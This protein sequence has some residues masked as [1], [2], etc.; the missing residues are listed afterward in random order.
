VVGGDGSLHDVVNGL[1]DSG[2]EPLPALLPYPVGVGND[3]AR[4]LGVRRGGHHLV[5][6]VR[7]GADQYVDAWRLAWP[8]GHRWF[9]NVASFGLSGTAAA[10]IDRQGKRFGGLS[11]PIGG[12]RAL[13]GHRDHLI[14]LEVPGRAPEARLLGTGILA[15]APW[16]GSRMHVAPGADSR[17]GLLE[18]LTVEG[19][20]RWRLAGMMAGIYFGRHLRSETVRRAQISAARISWEGTLAFEADGEPVAAASPVEVTAKPGALLFRRPFEP[21]R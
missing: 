15:N 2:I 5:R 8:A 4:H 7:G 19:A 6:A 11:Y 9:V 21:E 13:A 3:F 14:R 17:D 1:L 10:I 16:F 20:G 12:L 18:F